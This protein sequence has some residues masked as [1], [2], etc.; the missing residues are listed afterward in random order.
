MQRYADFLR[1][2]GFA[3][4]Y[5]AFHEHENPDMLLAQFRRSGSTA[6][7]YADTT[8]YLLERRLRRYAE[9]YQI[10]LRSYPSPNFLTTKEE[11]KNLLGSD[12]KYRMENFYINQ[13]KRL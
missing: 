12:R 4:E 9:K 8:D 10:A 5:I 7:H 13:R 1:E 2:H 6:I 11:L 3:V